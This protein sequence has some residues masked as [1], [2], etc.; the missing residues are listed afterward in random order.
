MNKPSGPVHNA[1]RHAQDNPPPPI[2]GA[3]VVGCGFNIL[4]TYSTESITS[5]IV[6]LG[7]PNSSTYQ[8]AGNTYSVPQNASP[9]DYSHKT[10]ASYLYNTQEQFQGH[11]AQKSGVSASYGAFSG[12]FNLAYS[13]TVNSDVACYYGIYE[14]DITTWELKVNQTAANWLTSEFVNDPDVQALPTTFTPENQEQFF[15]VFRK[16]GTHYV[17][18]V[19]LGGSLDYYSA[20]MTSYSSSQTQVKANIELEY[21][22]VFT[23][24]KATSEVQWAQLGQNWANSRTV[25][26]DATGGDSTPLKALSPT[27]GDS[28][29]D[30]FDTWSDSVAANPSVVEFTLRPMSLLFSGAQA[31]AV[32]QALFAYTNGAIVAWG[33]SDYTPGTGPGAATSPLHGG[34]TSTTSSPSRTRRSSS[35][36]QTCWHPAKWSR[37]AA[38]R[39]RCST[40]SASNR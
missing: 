34:S 32:Q 24:G 19:I 7:D 17:A 2:P 36:H 3:S 16:W 27:Y 28:D 13:N 4:G 37:S 33:A 26:V 38:I 39:S 29:S 22:A 15:A 6:S 30:I 40:R 14:T 23:S 20:V 10:G 12:Q 21:K 25:M 11:Y 9:V 31:S 35:R 1:H 5:Q 18:Q 8:Y